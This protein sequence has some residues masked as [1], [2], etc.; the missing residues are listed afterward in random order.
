MRRRSL[1]KRLEKEYTVPERLSADNIKAMLDRN[2]AVIPTVS[3]NSEVRLNSTRKGLIKSAALAAA[4]VLAVCGLTVSR[5]GQPDVEKP[6]APEEITHTVADTTGLTGLRGGSYKSLHSFLTEIGDNDS[7]APALPDNTYVYMNNEGDASVAS[8]MRSYFENCC[9]YEGESDVI[10]VTE[11]YATRK[12][13]PDDLKLKLVVQEEDMAFSA[14]YTDVEGYFLKEGEPVPIDYD[15]LGDTYMMQSLSQ[16]AILWEFGTT[17]KPYIIGMIIQDSKLYIAYSFHLPDS[18]GEYKVV[19]GYCGFCVY[20]LSDRDNISLI[21]EYEQPGIMTEFHMTEDGRLTIIGEFDEGKKIAEAEMYNS[22]VPKFLPQVYENGQSS[23]I[24]EDAIYIANKAR[25]CRLTIMSS[26]DMGNNEG[27]I[28]NTGCIVMTL[29]SEGIA[30]TDDHILFMTH[31]WDEVKWTPHYINVDTSDG[32]KITAAKYPE[33]LYYDYSCFDYSEENGVRYL[34]FTDMVVAIDDE[35]EVLGI[36]EQGVPIIEYYQEIEPDDPSYSSYN[37][38]YGHSCR[39]I[40]DGSTIYFGDD[41]YG[42][43]YYDNNIL[44]REIVDMSDP[45]KP[46]SNDVSL[47]PYAAP[48]ATGYSMWKD[49]FIRLNDKFALHRTYLPTTEYEEGD[50]VYGHEDDDRLVMQLISLDPEKTEET[51]DNY[52]YATGVDEDEYG[53]MIMPPEKHEAYNIRKPGV[54]GEADYDLLVDFMV[55]S[56]YRELI[57]LSNEEYVC[58]PIVNNTFETD[59]TEI[60]EEEYL[61]MPYSERTKVTIEEDEEGNLRYSHVNSTSY[62]REFLL[63]RFG[64]DGIENLGKVCKKTITYE[65]ADD[66]FFDSKMTGIAVHDGYVYCFGSF[67]ASGSKIPE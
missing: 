10:P 57:R 62:T 50:I 2:S 51:T 36:Y 54:I 1:L 30:I 5:W 47:A 35:L 61:E 20:D 60:T 11:S 55:T 19:N 28:K 58:F 3:A 4:S 29:V 46:I 16:N 32:L 23:T 7:Y 44:I 33:N 52:Y 26:F 42:Y 17:F 6:D 67:G 41:I 45:A 31:Y 24:S 8:N 13:M 56:N 18:V 15:F 14:D 43:S 22:G 12:R 66:V 21:Y 27:S 64:D 25:N 53:N 38:Y 37:S 49:S 34:A 63:F 9:V 39:P 65:R 59:E 48:A 40:L